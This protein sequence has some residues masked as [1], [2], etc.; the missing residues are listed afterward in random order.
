MTA[1]LP[2]VAIDGPAG[3]G[4][5]TVAQQLAR[6]CGL[7]FISSGMMYRAVAWL[8]L[9]HGVS[10]TDEPRLT[11]LARAHPLAF[12][13]SPD[14]RPEHWV[15]G[16]EV[17]AALQSPPVAQLASQIALL[18]AVRAEL[19][20]QQQAL[21]AHGGV[22]MEGRDIQTVVFPHAE[23]KVFLTASA[24]ERARR[25]WDEL[26]ARGEQ[27]DFSTVL[28]EVGAR[29]ARDTG[30]AV[31]P[32]QPASD[33]ILVD[34]DGRSIADVVANLLRLV[35][36]WQRAPTLRGAA[37]VRAAACPAAPPAESERGT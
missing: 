1:P 19:V 36:A 3:S 23:I 18:P 20:A 37:L 7:T 22:V 34:T 17:S 30:R 35:Q 16:E 25:R 5:S 9:R 14:G 33:A 31:A 13:R 29:D 15:T 8:A 32:L 27:L 6:A 2:I 10:A 12:R 4:K 11:A 26:R 28:A 24:E 21:G